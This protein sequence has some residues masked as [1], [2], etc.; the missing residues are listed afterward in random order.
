[1]ITARRA[2]VLLVVLL[3]VS[4]VEAWPKRKHVD[5]DTKQRNQ[6]LSAEALKDME[7]LLSGELGWEP[8]LD[9]ETQ[10]WKMT[11]PDSAFIFVKAMATIDASPVALREVLAPGEL[12]IVKMYNPVITEGRDIEYLGRDSKISWSSTMPMWP[13]R[14]RDFVTFINRIRLPDG[15]TAIIQ[16]ATTHPQYPAPGPGYDTVRAEILHGLFLVQPVP[17]ESHRSQFTMVQ[18]LNP[19]GKI[20][21]WLTNQL[22]ARTPASF[23]TALGRVAQRFDAV[24]AATANDATTTKGSKGS[25]S[26]PCFDRGFDS[27]PCPWLL[28]MTQGTSTSAIA[29]AAGGGSSG[30]GS[31]SSS[32]AAA[33]VSMLGVP[34]AAESAAGVLR[35]ARSWARGNFSGWARGNFMAAL[36]LAV[37]IAAATLRT[38]SS[39]KRRR[40]RSRGDSETAAAGAAEAE[41]AVAGATDRGAAVGD[42]GEGVPVQGA[43]AAPEGALSGEAATQGGEIAQGVQ[44]GA[45][46]AADAAGGEGALGSRADGADTLEPL[47]APTVVKLDDAAAAAAAQAP[48]DREG[49]AEGEGAAAVGTGGGDAADGVAQGASGGRQAAEAPA[50]KRGSWVAGVVA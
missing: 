26:G 31:V 8:V 5:K 28:N 44:N 12:D 50:L 9:G 25:R 34:Q 16:K 29:A 36:V 35:S 33:A 23:V 3:L 18:H 21:A 17:G 27:P 24:A 7:W 38:V 37:T 48:E 43:A 11:M 45:A 46:A 32:A 20:P 2:C 40:L 4:S 47:A 42:R 6:A 14:G 1:M 22:A 15:G 30:G 41:A 39:S 19:G 13:C 10:V 49:A